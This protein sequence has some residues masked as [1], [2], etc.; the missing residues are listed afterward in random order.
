MLAGNGAGVKFGGAS[1]KRRE[2]FGEVVELI[3]AQD[4]RKI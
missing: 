1:G 3:R 4:A 2:E